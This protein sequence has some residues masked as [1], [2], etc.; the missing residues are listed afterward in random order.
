MKATFFSITVLFAVLNISC[1]D[2]NPHT[3]NGNINLNGNFVFQKVITHTLRTADVNSLQNLKSYGDALSYTRPIWSDDG[4]KFAAIDLI[5]SVETGSTSVFAIKIVNTGDESVTTWEIGS[6]VHIYL[7][8]PLTWSPDGHTIAFLANPYNKIIYL[9][10]S[11]G[12]TTQTKLLLDMYEGVTALA[13]HPDSNKIAVNLRHW[14][15]YQSD[16]RICM[17]DPY[18]TKLNNSIPVVSGTFGIAHMDWDKDG[19]KLLLSHD[20]YN[21]IYVLNINTG[22]FKEIPNAYGLAPCWSPDGMYILYTG[23]SGHRGLDII[24]GLIVTDIEGS[25]EKILLTDAGY[26]DWY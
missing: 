4:T 18:G 22:Q 2:Y 12:D 11:N 19:T 20:L 9:N 5:S 25:F 23:I 21:D 17:I 24:P 7:V 3:D 6:S 15:N 16:N 26:C 1:N 13:W 8:G 10:T 14:Q